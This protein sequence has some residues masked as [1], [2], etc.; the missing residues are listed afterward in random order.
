MAFFPKKFSPQTIFFLYLFY[1]Q[2]LIGTECER[3]ISSYNFFFHTLITIDD[4]NGGNGN[5]GN[6]Y[7]HILVPPKEYSFKDISLNV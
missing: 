5:G 1:R 7:I 4:G 6:I 2:S 3:A